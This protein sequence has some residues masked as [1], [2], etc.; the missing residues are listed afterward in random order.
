MAIPD[1]MLAFAIV[2]FYVGMGMAELWYPLIPADL[3]AVGTMWTTKLGVIVGSKM[4]TS[5]CFTRHPWLVVLTLTHLI[6]PFHGHMR[7]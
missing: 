6:Y 5:I 4:R 7:Y 1:V 2:A 3:V